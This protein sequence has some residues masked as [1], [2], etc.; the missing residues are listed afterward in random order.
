[1]AAEK[2]S[3]ND[4]LDANEHHSVI[5]SFYQQITSKI[6]D[7]AIESQGELDDDPLEDVIDGMLDEVQFIYEKK[8][9]RH[10]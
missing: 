7:M 1:M 2:Q 10:S 4:S 9:L 5:A 3:I 6:E 8:R